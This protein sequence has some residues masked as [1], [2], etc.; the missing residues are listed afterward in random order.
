MTEPFDIQN[1][2]RSC[3]EMLILG[4]I[5]R[6]RM[7]GYQIALEIEDRSGG[8]FQFNHGTLYPILHHLEKQGLIDGQWTEGQGRRKRKEYVLSEQGTA[9]LRERADEWRT[10]CEQL[11]AFVADGRDEPVRAGAAAHQP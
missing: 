9:H 11:S 10:L 6:Q 2:A 8:F 5:G 3:N 4:A 7:H 1:L